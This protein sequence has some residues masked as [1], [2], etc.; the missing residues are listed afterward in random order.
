MFVLSYL[1][2]NSFYNLTNILNVFGKFQDKT[3]QNKTISYTY[4][5]NGLDNIAKR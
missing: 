4:S 1:F 2:T 3:K 5:M